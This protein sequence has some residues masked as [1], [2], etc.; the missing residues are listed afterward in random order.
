MGITYSW[1]SRGEGVPCYVDRAPLNSSP[2]E[3]PGVWIHILDI[4]YSI[5]SW[6]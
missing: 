2:R 3:P 4:I 1:I 6:I 5:V